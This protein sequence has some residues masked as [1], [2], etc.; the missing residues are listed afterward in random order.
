MSEKQ[1]EKLF[2]MAANKNVSLAYVTQLARHSY[3]KKPLSIQR[4]NDIASELLS[5]SIE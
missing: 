3:F 5:E 4:H 1:T 2:Q